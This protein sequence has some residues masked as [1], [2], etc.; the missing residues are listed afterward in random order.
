MAFAQLDDLRGSI[1]LVIFSDVY[2]RRRALVTSGR[3]VAVAGTIDLAR[4]DPKVKVDDMMEPQELARR[5]VRAVHVRLREEA[6]SEEGL[7]R[8]LEFMLDHRGTCGVYLH[9]GGNGG[10]VI[11][12]SAQ[13]LVSDA[14]EVLAGIREH[15]EVADAWRE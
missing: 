13:I 15:P 9:L 2:E 1:E 5:E 7:Q 12:A 3:I 14:D 8:L 10:T 4:G 6:G 11:R